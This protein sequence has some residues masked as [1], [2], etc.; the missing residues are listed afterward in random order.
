M[1]TPNTMQKSKKLPENKNEVDTKLF[2]GDWDC[3]MTMKQ[4]IKILRE[5]IL[6]LEFYSQLWQVHYMSL[7]RFW[8]PFVAIVAVR[9]NMSNHSNLSQTDQAVTPRI[10]ACPSLSDLNKGKTSAFLGSC[11]RN[12]AM[13]PRSTSEW[14]SLRANFH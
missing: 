4:N 5:K 2:T 12:Y 8:E 14:S 6:N 1:R 3:K 7:L 9:D 13:E 10:L 11:L